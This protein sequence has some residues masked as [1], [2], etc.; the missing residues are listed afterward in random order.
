MH[1]FRATEYNVSRLA[2]PAQTKE[3]KKGKYH[4][5]FPDGNLPLSRTVHLGF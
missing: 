1:N 5:Q 2:F 4:V 3:M